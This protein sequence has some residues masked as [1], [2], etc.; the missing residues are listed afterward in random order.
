MKKMLCVFL[1]IALPSALITAGGKAES[2]DG[3]GKVTIE[4]W[5]INSA[6]FGEKTENLL[7]E[8]LHK[9]HPK[10]TVVPCFRQGSYGRLVQN[11]Q[12]KALS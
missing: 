12:E 2:A 6:T 7:V 5:Y 9:L 4:Y 3:K 10:I 1:L 11:L 8:K